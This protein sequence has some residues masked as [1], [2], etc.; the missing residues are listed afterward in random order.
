[1]RD[2]DL[3][4]PGVVEHL[5][6]FI[7]AERDERTVGAI[8]LEL[9]G[10]CALLRSAVVAPAERGAGIGGALVAAVLDLARAEGVRTLYLL[11]TSA[12]DYW[13]RHG[14]SRIPREDIPEP[15]RQ[16]AEF[17]GACP[18]SAVAMVRAV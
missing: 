18:A 12:E 11:T 10:D 9:R 14:F 1:V 16:S 3:A 2:A 7:V 5:G 8:G 4:V 15:V 17:A 6:A 13:S